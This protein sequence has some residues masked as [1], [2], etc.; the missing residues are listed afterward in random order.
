LTDAAP[1][2]SEARPLLLIDGNRNGDAVLFDHDAHAGRQ[3]G[4]DSCSVCH[5]LDEP[6]DRYPP[7]VDCHRDM[8]EPVSAFDHASHAQ[9]LGGNAGCVECH[10]APAGPKDYAT[11]TACARCHDDLVPRY[12]FV[13]APQDR[14][15]AAVGYV[16]AMHGLCKKCHAQKVFAEPG[17]HP[18][19]LDRC[20]TCHDTDRP[21]DL[22]RLEPRVHDRPATRA[23]THPGEEEPPGRAPTAGGR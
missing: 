14:W 19:T 20:D 5:H 15:K 16:D 9:A 4:A 1:S 18:A 10:P 8:Y 6:F 11:A 23:S 3:H 21:L 12:S 22:R 7:C 13:G 2:G 17:R